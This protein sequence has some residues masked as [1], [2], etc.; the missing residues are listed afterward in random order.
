MLKPEAVQ[1][2]GLALHDI[3]E[4]RFIKLRVDLAFEAAFNSWSY[5]SRFPRVATDLRNGLDPYVAMTHAGERSSVPVMYWEQEGGVLKIYG[6]TDD[7]DPDDPDEMAYLLGQI[8]GGEPQEGWWALA[9]DF[10]EIYDR[11]RDSD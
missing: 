9:H 11:P 6:R 1:N 8:D 3:Y 5:R 10:L 4:L 2:L 7:W